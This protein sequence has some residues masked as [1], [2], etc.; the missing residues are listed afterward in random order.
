MANVSGLSSLV[1]K[2]QAP[3]HLRSVQWLDEHERP[4]PYPAAGEEEPVPYPARP[5]FAQ[6][7]LS[8]LQRICGDRGNRAA[9]HSRLPIDVGDRR[10]C[11]KRR[12][13]PKTDRP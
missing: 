10:W 1:V 11:A 8:R 6:F 3:S 2:S 9:L 5:L 7:D 4:F 13:V 12:L